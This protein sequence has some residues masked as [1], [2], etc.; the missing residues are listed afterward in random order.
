MAQSLLLHSAFAENDYWKKVNTELQEHYGVL[1]SEQQLR[2]FGNS[3]NPCAN[4]PFS[5]DGLSKN[6]FFSYYKGNGLA[7]VQCDLNVTYEGK[8]QMSIRPSDMRFVKAC[9]EKGLIHIASWFEESGQKKWWIFGPQL[10][11]FRYFKPVETYILDKLYE[12]SCDEGYS[13]SITNWKSAEKLFE[14]MTLLARIYPGNELTSIRFEEYSKYEE[15][16]ERLLLNRLGTEKYGH[17]QSLLKA[18]IT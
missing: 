4:V 12:H 16:R 10:D 15:E 1:L 18:Q 11:H 14:A 7:V 6:W 13:R 3:Q 9:L 5:Q 2:D 8:Q 17:L